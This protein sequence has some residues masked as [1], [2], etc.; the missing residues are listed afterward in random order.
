MIRLNM[1]Q[2]EIIGLCSFEGPEKVLFPFLC[3]A[4]VG[5]IEDGG[6]CVFNEV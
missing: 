1:V 6:F 4:A 3:S 2:Y 5:R